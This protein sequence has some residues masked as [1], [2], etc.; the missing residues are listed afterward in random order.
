MISKDAKLTIQRISMECLQVKMHEPRHVERLL[1]YISVIR[2]HPQSDI[3]LHVTPSDT[4]SGMYCILDGHHR[5]IASIMTGRKDALCV[6]IEE[7]E[8]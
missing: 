6:V 4:H 5:F 7:G 3:L 8:P 1:S 2:Q